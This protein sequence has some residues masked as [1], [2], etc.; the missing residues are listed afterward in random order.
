MQEGIIDEIKKQITLA[1]KIAKLTHD[2][3]SEYYKGKCEAYKNCL[4][5]INNV[6][7]GDKTP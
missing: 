5:I 7:D 6:I 1:S 3:K 4:Q 2:N